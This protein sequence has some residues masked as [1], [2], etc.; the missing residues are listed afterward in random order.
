MA[1]QPST[2][3]HGL[4]NSV[5]LFISFRNIRQLVSLQAKVSP[6][7]PLFIYRHEPEPVVLSFGEFNARVHQ[8]AHLLQEDFG[9]GRGDTVN[10]LLKPGNSDLPVILTACWLIGAAA[11]LL[12][13]D[14][15]SLVGELPETSVALCLTDS[16]DDLSR[17]T[18]SADFRYIIQVGGQATSRY[19]RF[20]ELVSRLPNTF[21]N[22]EAELTDAALILYH[23][24][25][26]IRLTQVDLL[27][28]A[29]R[30]ALAQGIGGNQH[31]MSVTPAYTIVDLVWTF[32]LPLLV[33]GTMVIQPSVEPESFWRRVA[34]DRIHV[35][36]ITIDLL[37][38][39][40]N[41]AATNA[42]FGRGVYQQDIRQLRHLLCF[43]GLSVDLLQAFESRFGMAV[44]TGY[45]HH[46]APGLCSLMPIDLTWEARQ[47]WSARDGALGVG[48]SLPGID[49]ALLNQAGQVSG[50]GEI[51]T[52]GW[53]IQPADEWL[54]TDESGF[55]ELDERRRRFF[56]V[57]PNDG[58]SG[59][60]GRA[61]GTV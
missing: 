32:I 11:A 23:Q 7:Q 49:M 9:I 6:E 10:L 28:M 2:P 17:L 8:T 27:M 20:H 48:C 55:Y 5:S 53:R 19:P 43:D 41:L 47:H 61:K 4:T 16:P 56:F 57:R 54:L 3:K 45:S 59:H 30:V 1:A 29:Q 12:D 36:Q 44:M 52:V 39:C 35:A 60:S 25:K 15:P 31:L 18:Q 46:A 21:F 13:P 50:P 22:D 34:A 42:I 33:G 24:D 26:P 14:N 40:L 38:A 51:G 37:E 58:A